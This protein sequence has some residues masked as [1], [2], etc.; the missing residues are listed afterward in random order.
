MRP[1]ETAVQDLKSNFK[2]GNTGL[3]LQRI[4]KVLHPNS[5]F[6]DELLLLYSRFNSLIGERRNSMVSRDDYLA[7]IQNIRTSLLQ[8]I[9]D[10]KPEDIAKN[11]HIREEFHEK[12]LVVCPSK[13]REKKLSRYFPKV[14]FPSLEFFEAGKEQII[15]DYDILI[16]DNMFEPGSA[17]DNWIDQ[18]KTYLETEGPYILYL[19][20]YLEL[21]QDYSEKAYATNSVFSIYARL[22][23]LSEYMKYFGREKE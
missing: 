2:K 9:N 8:L 12:I 16:F 19:G 21:L 22:K 11:Y 18:L 14:Y 7:E 17:P 5:V 10:L 4:E 6:Q 1:F 13:S 23:E 20:G 15:Q 3:T